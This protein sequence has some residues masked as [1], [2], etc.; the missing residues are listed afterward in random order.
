VSEPLFFVERLPDPSQAV[1]LTPEDTRH[2]LRALRLREGD[3]V[4]LSDGAGRAGRGVLVGHAAG[5]ASVRVEEVG[6][7][8]RPSPSIAVALA[9]PKGDRLSW[10]VQKLTEVGVD[11]IVLLASE[12]S[13]RVLSAGDAGLAR[14]RAVAREAAMQSH[15]PYLPEVLTGELFGDVGGEWVRVLL[16]PIGDVRVSEA[17]PEAAACV[18][19]LIGPEGGWTDGELDRA[20]GAGAAIARLGPTILRTETAAVVAG[21]LA[22]A[23]YG[24]MG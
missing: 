21:T 5:R 1:D 13:V 2:A 8:D 18:E 6:L 14:Q 11:R 19:L 9:P 7:V 3:P 12:R 20:R 23:R 10:A 17:L 24:R 15:R 16:D 4:A 22:L